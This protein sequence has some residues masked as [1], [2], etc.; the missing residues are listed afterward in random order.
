MIV[1]DNGTRFEEGVFPQ[2]C[3]RLKIKQALTSVYHPQ[4]NGLT[5]VKN[6]EIFKG[7]EKRLIRTQKGW[8]DELPQVLWAHRTSPKKS[9]EESA[10]S[11]TYGTEAVLPIEISIPTKRTR[12]VDPS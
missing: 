9:N 12:K 10:F 11:L 3:E 1:S 5:E 2:F 8:V 6:K 7:I 4:G